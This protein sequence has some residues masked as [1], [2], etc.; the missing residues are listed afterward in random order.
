MRYAV[1]LK[2]SAIF[3]DYGGYVVP[4]P[5]AVSFSGGVPVV[6]ALWATDV[7]SAVER[8][9]LAGATSA[10]RP[11]F[12]LVALSTWDMGYGQACD[13]MKRLG[14]SFEAV[15]PD[16]FVGLIRQAYGQP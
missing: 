1:D 12:V 9:R 7:P 6:H 8:I 16:H 13:V 14:A 2:P 5:P 11:A 3:T 4:N 15:R 10:T